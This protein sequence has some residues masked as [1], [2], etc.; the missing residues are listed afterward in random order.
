MKRLA[1]VLVLLGLAA[2]APARQFVATAD[3]FQCLLDG[4][5]APGKHFFVFHRK[6]AALRKALHKI[7]TAKFGKKGLPVGTILQLVPFEAMVKRGGKFNREGNG[8]EF[9][10]L[11]DNADGTTTIVSRGMADVLSAFTHTSCQ[12]CHQ[13]LAADHESICEYVQGTAGIGL[14]DD[15]LAII[16]NG[17]PRCK[18]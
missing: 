13:R 3:D 2:P 6:K 12:D 10:S 15:L 16:Q 1:I 9:F 7:E 4:T 18:K 11:H 8:W 17:D 14:T 5:Q